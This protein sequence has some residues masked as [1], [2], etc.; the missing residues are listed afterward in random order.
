MN[1]KKE[2]VASQ[3]MGLSMEEGIF[4]KDIKGG[5][6]ALQYVTGEIIEIDPETDKRIL[7]KIDWHLLPWMFGLY[8]LQYL[9]KTALS[10]A[11]IMGIQKDN[12]LTTSQYAW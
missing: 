2:P 11:A 8:M 5:D 6:A 1:N 4:V 12:H 7:S 10:Y 3:E 9:D